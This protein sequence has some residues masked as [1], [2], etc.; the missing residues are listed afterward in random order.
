MIL[1]T[2]R[3]LFE[4]F[5]PSPALPP[6]I[7]ADFRLTGAS[8]ALILIHGFSGDARSTWSGMIDHLLQDPSTSSW[9][10]IALGFPSNL[11]VDVPNVW[12]ADPELTIVARA[13]STTLSLAPFKDYQALAI[14]AHSMGGLVAQRALLDDPS[15]V[16]RL[17]NL[18][19]FGTPSGGLPKARLLSRLKRQFRDMSPKSDF[20]KSLR[21]DWKATFGITPPFD[22]R[23]IAGDVDAFVPPASSLVPFDTQFQAVVPGNHLEIVKPNR[24]AHQSVRIIVESLNGRN[25]EL[26][27]VDSARLAVELG[28]FKK[29]V[30]ALEPHA[31]ELDD[32]GIVSLALALEGMGRGA[33]ALA[34]LENFC[35]GGI[36]STEAL[37]T[38]A[39]RIK[40]RW[41]VGRSAADFSRALSL[42]E[43]GL[44]AAE[45]QGDSDQAF[46]HAINVA[47]LRLMALPP[48]SAVTPECKNMA[49]RAL[50]HCQKCPV[51]RWRLATEGEALFI[52]GRADEAFAAYASA[53]QSTTSQREIDSMWSQAFRVVERLYSKEKLMRLEQAFGLRG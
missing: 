29:A 51:S 26:P 22:L 19:I 45:A 12:E 50:A 9:D 17:S 2:I 18:F 36:S 32:N 8:A 10:I 24:A 28:Q 14:A 52:L 16:S 3:W 31:S 53:I 40:R 6:P 21:S 25:R 15:L 34:T 38:L 30:A 47:F 7:Q 42:Y 23:V 11:R 27:P 44:A 48:T 49:E 1:K 39:G 13:L 35:N 43:Q 5:L 46:Y 20:I 4:P 37:G 33:E 41:I